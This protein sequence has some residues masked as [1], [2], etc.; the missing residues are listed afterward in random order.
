M[1]TAGKILLTLVLSLAALNCGAQIVNRLKVDSETFQ[2]YAAGR[3]QQ[4]NTDNLALAD[5]LYAE[6]V[7]KDNFR[8]KCL[9]LSLELPVRFSRGEYERMDEV[10][11]EMKELTFP[12][13]DCRTFYYITLHEYC[14]YLVHIGRASEAMLEARAMERLAEEEKGA[15]GKMYAYRIVGLIHSYRDN[16]YLAVKNLSNAVRFCKEARME[17]DLPIIYL[18]IARECIKMGNYPKALEYCSMAAEY[19]QFSARIRVN[20]TMT[21]AYYYYAQGDTEKFSECY[22]RLTSDP[23]YRHLSDN[24]SRLELDIFDLSL[25][26]LPDVALTKADSLGT[27]IGRFSH[28]HS[29]YAQ[30]GSYH[31][32]YLQ[33]DSLMVQKDS[34]YIKVQNED[35]AILDAEMNNAQLR[36]EAQQLRTRNQNTILIGF[37]VMF[38]IAFLS[39]LYQ[40]WHLRSNLDRLK[41][42]NAAAL[43]A[44]RAYRQALDAKEA[45]NAVKIKILQ[46]RNIK[47]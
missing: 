32:A 21:L 29:L 3:L 44:R 20:V 41:Q 26:N 27:S 16:H 47:L 36:H 43:L 17:Q 45:E 40:Q 10:A 1:R 5:S 25:R 18:L 46:S 34:V 4:Y 42:H 30:T 14:E 12:H 19:Q 22:S 37:I 31:D 39:V 23:V 11:A 33:L 2:R 9:G 35:L 6:G 38:A 13:K 28:R 15:L 7:R 24:D 8:I